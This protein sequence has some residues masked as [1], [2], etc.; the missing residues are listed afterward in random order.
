MLEGDFLPKMTETQAKKRLD[1]ACTKIMKVTNAAMSAKLAGRR[2]V[3]MSKIKEL[4]KLVMDIQRCKRG[5]F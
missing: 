5:L 1:E 4:N 2:G 3:N